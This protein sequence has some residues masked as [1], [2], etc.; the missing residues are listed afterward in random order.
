MKKIF[1]LLILIL[2]VAA[3]CSCNSQN[4]VIVDDE[5]TVETSNNITVESTREEISHEHTSEFVCECD[6]DME[7]ISDTISAEEET[8]TI[9][10]EQRELDFI[11][12]LRSESSEEEQLEVSF[13]FNGKI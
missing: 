3:L 6:S 1:L 11:S 8:I 4:N 10:T 2:S 9:D 7:T 13:S 5:T 12:S